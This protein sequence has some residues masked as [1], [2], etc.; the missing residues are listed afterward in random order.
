MSLTRLEPNCSG[1]IITSRPRQAVAKWSFS[2]TVSGAVLV[3]TRHKNPSNR[4]PCSC[5]K[6]RG[7]AAFVISKP[8]GLEF[9]GPT[10]GIFANKN[11]VAQV[12]DEHLA[13]LTP[14]DFLFA[15]PTRLLMLT[16]NTSRRTLWHTSPGSQFIPELGSPP[17]NLNL[18][19]ASPPRM[20][21]SWPDVHLKR[22]DGCRARIRTWTRSSKG[23][24]ATVT[25]PGID[26]T[27]RP[28]HFIIRS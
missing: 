25:L 22:N 26:A 5:V 15:H 20:R 7:A 4:A 9:R 1:R 11:E 12:W 6:L 24:G 10:V 19:T 21:P 3:K 28:A 16:A 23:S 18:R 13:V 27:K 8:I 17:R 14:L 2:S